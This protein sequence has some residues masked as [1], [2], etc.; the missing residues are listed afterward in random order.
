[1]KK[2]YTALRKQ[3]S[4]FGIVI[5]LV[6]FLILAI[7]SP[8]FFTINNLDSLQTSIAPNAIIAIGMMMLMI[9]G[10]FDLSVGS[11][12]C[13]SGV[14]TAYLLSRGMGIF[15]AV[16]GG[17]LT[18][19]VIGTING[20]L[21]AY[22]GIEPL[23]ATIG[24]MYVFRGISET[25]MT[26]DL[27][28]SLTGFPEGFNRFGSGKFLGLYSMVWICI[29]LLALF[30][31]L[32]KRT[33]VGRKGFYIGCSREN[34]RLMG[35]NVKRHVLGVYILSGMLSAIAGILSIARFETA[36]RYLGKDLQMTIMIACIMGG[37][38]LLGGKGDIQGALFGTLFIS[39]L[40]NGFNLFE[41]NPQWQ[42]V[43][44]GTILFLVVAADG[45]LYIKRMRKKGKI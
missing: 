18:G 26:S 8:Y 12:M 35:I 36:S 3:D 31:F 44:I 21:V 32:T 13:L 43:T 29:L 19:A 34:A 25:I 30:I 11:V 37:G 20:V 39:F 10:M 17:M 33:Y 9:M 7:F 27:A 40:S 4:F 22:G 28:T 23:I 45:F 14:V 24:T 5:T 2:W 41:I 42:N 38:S 1:M 15:A 6:S 16:A